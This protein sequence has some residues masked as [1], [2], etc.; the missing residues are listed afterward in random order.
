MVVQL[1]WILLPKMNGKMQLPQLPV[2]AVVSEVA[3]GVLTEPKKLLKLLIAMDIYLT[4]LGL[5]F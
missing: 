1:E 4:K 5:E 3:V 2:E